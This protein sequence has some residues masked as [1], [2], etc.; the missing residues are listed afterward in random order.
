MASF[1][2]Q[3]EWKPV[4]ERPEWMPLR[5]CTGGPFFWLCA[6]FVAWIFTRISLPNDPQSEF[7]SASLTCS[8]PTTPKPIHFAFPALFLWSSG[9]I[10]T[11]FAEFGAAPCFGPPG[12]ASF[13]W[14]TRLTRCFNAL[15]LH[16]ESTLLLV[17]AL[18][19]LIR[20]PTK[21]FVGPW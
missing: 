9:A 15:E 13:A 21:P 6:H 17:G 12:L 5:T 8:P 19:E 14:L 18:A 4:L 10:N 2:A 7:P 11:A 3:S 20:V 16:F 1:H